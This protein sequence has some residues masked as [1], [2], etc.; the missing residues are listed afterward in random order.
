MRFA[1]KNYCKID[2]YAYTVNIYPIKFL[3]EIGKTYKNF[4]FQIG[5]AIRKKHLIQAKD[6]R[7]YYNYLFLFTKVI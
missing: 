3:F 5:F 4:Y 1:E 2:N 7:Y 6:F